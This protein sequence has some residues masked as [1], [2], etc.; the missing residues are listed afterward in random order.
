MLHV[1]EAE[2]QYL[3]ESHLSLFKDKSILEQ[4]SI[5]PLKI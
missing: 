2:G 3:V 1:H 5:L 4:E